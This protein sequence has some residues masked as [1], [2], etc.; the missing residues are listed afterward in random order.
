[1]DFRGCFAAGGKADGADKEGL[2]KLGRELHSQA[3]YERFARV[4]A[5]AGGFLGKLLPAGCRQREVKA[6]TGK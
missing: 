2:V 3:V 1:M 4:F 5:C 6:Q